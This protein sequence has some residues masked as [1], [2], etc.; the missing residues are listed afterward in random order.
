MQPA[1]ESKT[2][3]RQVKTLTNRFRS[4]EDLYR[5]LTQQSN[6]IHSP[7]RARCRQSVSTEF[8]K[9]TYGIYQGHPIGEEATSQAK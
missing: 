2:E 5:Y 9:Y 4:K 8:A 3:M 1:E 7:Y 6:S